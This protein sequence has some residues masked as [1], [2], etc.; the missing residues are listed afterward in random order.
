[1]PDFPALPAVRPFGVLG[2]Y[3]PA[4]SICGEAV[5]LGASSAVAGV[6]PVANLAIYMP[7]LAERAVTVKQI[8]IQVATQA[9]NVD[10][11]I[12]TEGGT[13]LV[14]AGTTAVAV[15]GMQ[16]FDITDTLLTPATYYLAMAA[17]SATAS[18]A[19]AAVP[20]PLLRC[21]G[22]RQEALGGL[23]LPATAT[24]ADMAQGYVPFICATPQA[25]I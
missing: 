11:G 23:P 4:S 16:L 13:R 7:I 15:A 9:G 20:A 21:A 18:F 5:A 17:S 8:A 2:S 3:D 19:K 1:M 24:F 25:V 12:Y 14:A 10:V 22:V 6:W